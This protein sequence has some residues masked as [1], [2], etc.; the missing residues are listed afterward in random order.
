MSKKGA[1]G[2]VVRLYEWAHD[3][4]TKCVDCRPIYVQDALEDAGF[5]T[6]SVAE[7]SM[8]GLPVEIVLS[9]KRKVRD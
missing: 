2:L 5:L 1:R 7:M 8:F 3:I 4:F 9:I 6:G